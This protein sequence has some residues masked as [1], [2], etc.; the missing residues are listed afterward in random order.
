MSLVKKLHQVFDQRFFGDRD[1]IP[2]RHLFGTAGSMPSSRLIVMGVGWISVEESSPHVRTI[3]TI[4]LQKVVAE[5][6][7]PSNHTALICHKDEGASLP[8][9]T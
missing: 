8:F 7:G 6:G 4:T 9:D 5:G 1:D 3:I 2:G